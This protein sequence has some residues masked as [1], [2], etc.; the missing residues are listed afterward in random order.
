MNDR[1]RARRAARARGRR[2]TAAAT[3]AA[4]LGGTVL[5]TV[6]GVTLAQHATAATSVPGSP[7]PSAPALTPPAPAGTSA[8]L[9]TTPGPAS[10]PEARPHPTASAPR[11]IHPPAQPPATGGHGGTAGSSGGS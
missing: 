8:P 1:Q 6:F 4:G 2:H 5:A 11:V 10:T 9:V 3:W 7:S